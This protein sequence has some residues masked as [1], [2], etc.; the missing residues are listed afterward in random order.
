MRGCQH[1]G[2]SSYE[3]TN[4]TK[5]F[6]E[7]NSKWVNQNNLRK[8]VIEQKAREQETRECTFRP[9]T[10]D[11]SARIVHKKPMP[12]ESRGEMLYQQKGKKVHETQ[13]RLN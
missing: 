5:S 3:I 11:K 2:M 9:K 8:N 10:N 12:Y 1:S 7:R 4:D 13:K 6:M